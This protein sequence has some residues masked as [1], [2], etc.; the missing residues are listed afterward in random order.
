MWRKTVPPGGEEGGEA[1][2]QA[3]VRVHPPSVPPARIQ[4]VSSTQSRG[5]MTFC[6]DPDPTPFFR[7]F[8]D[9]KQINFSYFNH[10]HI[11][12]KLKNLMFFSNFVLKYY[13]ASIISVRSTLL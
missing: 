1:A 7:D 2:Q 12:F 10:R 13:F 4:Q 8:K 9:A 5:S 3:G 6:P 11:I